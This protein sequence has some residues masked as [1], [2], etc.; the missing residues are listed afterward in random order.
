MEM[1]PITPPVWAKYFYPHLDNTTEQTGEYNGVYS[2][3]EFA[4]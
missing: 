3:A 1:S 2:L 4:C